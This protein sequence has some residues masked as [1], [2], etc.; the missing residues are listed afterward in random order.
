MLTNALRRGSSR[1]ARSGA[2]KLSLRRAVASSLGQSGM[3]APV[4]ITFEFTGKSVR[5]RA[6]GGPGS[7]GVTH[8]HF[9][10]KSPDCSADYPTSEQ[11]LFCS[12]I[13]ARRIEW[14]GYSGSWL[15]HSSLVSNATGRRYRRTGRPGR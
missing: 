1:R 3:R 10:I 8:L 2:V 11:L 4:D 15:L 6:V 12:S 9:S 13:L 14:D 5:P 7:T